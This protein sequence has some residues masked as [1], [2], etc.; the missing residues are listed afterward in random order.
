[1]ASS[2]RVIKLRQRYTLAAAN[3]GVRLSQLVCV[4]RRIEQ[5]PERALKFSVLLQPPGSTL[6]CIRGY[7]LAKRL[8][9]VACSNFCFLHRGMRTAES[10]TITNGMI[11]NN[12]TVDINADKTFAGVTI[13]GILFVKSPNKLMVQWRG[14]SPDV[15]A[16]HA[17]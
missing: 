13:N 12:C 8:N 11:L 9:C 3:Q 2:N 1:M 16:D 4:S 5:R 14:S 17:G 10:T 7:R 15:E 6:A